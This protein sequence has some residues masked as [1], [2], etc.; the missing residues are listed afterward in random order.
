MLP[1]L[2]QVALILALL[3]AALQ[4][5]LPLVGAQRGLGAWMAVAR[6]AAFAQLALVASAFAILT[7]AFVTQDF[8][9]QYVATNSNSLLPMVYRYTAVWGAHEGSLLLWALILALWTG[10]V[11]LFSKA[12]PPAVIARV[13]GVMGLVA[14][15]FLAFLIFTSNPFGR[16]LPAAVEGR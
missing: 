1:E 12:L 16:L 2:G 7:H 5:V 9:L 14:F 13:L 3:V 4:A 6:P 8:S 10:A 11:A 15:G